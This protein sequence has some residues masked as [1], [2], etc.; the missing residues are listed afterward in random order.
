MSPSAYIAAASFAVV[1]VMGGLLYI[2][3]K[4]ATAAAQRASQQEIRA[5]TAEQGWKAERDQWR[6]QQEHADE[7]ERNKQSSQRN[8]EQ[9]G[10]ELSQER[11][12]G[13]NL[14]LEAPVTAGDGFTSFVA[15]WMCE[16]S[17]AG[18]DYQ[19]TCDIDAAANPA[20]AV[21]FLQIFTPTVAEQWA[22][23]CE[24]GQRDFCEYVMVGFTWDGWYNFQ[25]YLMRDLVA[26]Q[27]R[28]QS[29][30]YYE[31]IVGE[32]KVKETEE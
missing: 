13:F 30:K 19:G 16:K 5:L 32:M 3:D 29:L 28:A 12:K 24:A 21:N 26:T 8:I 20:A 22:E 1:A 31:R 2:K 7:L 10:I 17:A 9:L 6:L 11:A 27:G 15:W 25:N 18:G 4:Q 14:A 23:L